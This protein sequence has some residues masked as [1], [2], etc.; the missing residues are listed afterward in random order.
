MAGYGTKDVKLLVHG[1]NVSADIDQVTMKTSAIVQEFKPLGAVFPT[2]YDTGGRTGELTASGIY[3]SI[4]SES[5]IL[6]VVSGT[7]RVVA[8]VHEGD[9]VSSRAWCFQKAIVSAT[10][11]GLAPDTI[12]SLT[13]EFTVTGTVNNAYVVAP[14]VAR[15]TAG[16]TQSTYADMAVA[17]TGGTARAFLVV[18]SLT[19]GGYTNL[20]VTVQS[21]ATSGGSYDDET[22]FTA[23]TAAGA[24]SVAL[25][26]DVNRYLAVKW[27]WTG[28]GTGQ[29]AT[30]W[31]GVSRD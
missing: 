8:V 10:E 1:S 22:A 25:S 21:C 29:S 26:G 14:L 27:A 16:N 23:V 4:P 3:N 9:T 6:A 2:T 13:P 11:I 15:T 20:I 30:F 7:D 24:E 31:V 28:A 19:L 18:T 17:A 12:H 5:P